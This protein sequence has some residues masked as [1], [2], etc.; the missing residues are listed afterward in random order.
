M[1]ETAA[2]PASRSLARARE[3]A[4][5]VLFPAALEVDRADRVPP[6]HLDLLAAEGFYGLAAPEDLATLDLPDYPAVFQAVAELAG[7]CLTTAFVWVQHHGAVMA[8]GETANDALRAD[9]LPDLV[10]GRRRAGLAVGAAVRPGPPLVRAER[11]DG[12]WLFDGEA[13]WVTGWGMVDTLYAAGR[14]ADDVIVW[15][16]L[17][18]EQRAGLSAGPVLDLVAVQASRT[19]TLR[20]DRHFVP[21]GR[22]LGTVPQ[23]EHLKGDAESVRFTGALS[24]GLAERATGLL[25]GDAGALPD[26]LDEVRARLLSVE[27]E[28]VPEA[29]AAAAELA[30][31]AASACAVA[32]GSRSVLLQEHAQRLVREATFLLL[33]G[34]RPGIRTALLDRLTHPAQGLSRKDR[35]DAP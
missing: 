25:R 11:A 17:D 19:V 24:L 9:H 30:L 13:P 31:R 5:D 20:F 14:D 29:R 22:V 3:I 4:D 27:P 6:S 18:A 33:F 26:E 12:G 23:R 8:L 1:S 35:G 7:G 34:S 21:D 2:A 28:Q 10:A 32:H 16:L 15:A